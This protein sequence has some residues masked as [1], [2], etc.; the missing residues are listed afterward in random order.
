MRQRPGGQASRNGYMSG[1]DYGSRQ[2]TGPVNQV[3]VFEEEAFIEPAPRRPAPV[4]TMGG[5]VP[6]RNT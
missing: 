3:G 5:L 2:A 1:A 4:G 6:N